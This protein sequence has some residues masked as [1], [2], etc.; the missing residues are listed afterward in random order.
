MLSFFL[1]SVPSLVAVRIQF[2][3]RTSIKKF[4]YF[5]CCL[6]SA[7]YVVWQNAEEWK[8]QYYSAK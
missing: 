1:V 5:A 4:T 7:S 6:Q 3:K 2:N 8:N